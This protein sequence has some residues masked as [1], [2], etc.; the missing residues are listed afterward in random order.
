[1]RAQLDAAITVAGLPKF[2]ASFGVTDSE[3]GEELAAAL[4]RA[5]DALLAAKRQGRDRVVFY[6]AV[7]NEDAAETAERQ[8]SLSRN[9]DLAAAEHG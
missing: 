2:T 9:G 4:R 8:P 3:P 1:V 7:V 6:D 5:D